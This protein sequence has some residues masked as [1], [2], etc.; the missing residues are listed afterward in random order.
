MNYEELV[1]WAARKLSEMDNYPFDDL[2]DTATSFNEGNPTKSHYLRRAKAV[3][4]GLSERG[5]VLLDEDQSFSTADLG[6]V[7]SA[8]N[9]E[10]RIK[11]QGFRR[12]ILED[13]AE[14]KLEREGTQ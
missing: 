8:T 5:M 10:L 6:T 14:I 1:E 12:V 2:K 3:L 4:E 7:A 11:S 9:I 13:I